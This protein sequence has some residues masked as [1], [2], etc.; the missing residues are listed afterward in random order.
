[1]VC[2]LTFFITQ[3]TPSPTGEGWGEQIAWRLNQIINFP[4]ISVPLLDA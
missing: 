4:A 3:Q 2:K 1:M